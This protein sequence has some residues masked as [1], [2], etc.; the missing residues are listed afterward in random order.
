MIG[1]EGFLKHG[2]EL[3]VMTVP[4]FFT[5]IISEITMFITMLYIGRIDA[6]DAP[7]YIGAA[8]LGKFIGLSSVYRLLSMTFEIYFRK[9]VMR[10]H[11]ILSYQWNVH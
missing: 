10:C 2:K 5:A 7:V 3:I 11:W 6:T 9:Y 4:L 8:T 1:E